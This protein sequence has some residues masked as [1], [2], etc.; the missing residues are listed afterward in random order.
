ML[1]VALDALVNGGWLDAVF[2]TTLVG[3]VVAAKPFDS[4][5]P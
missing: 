1:I 2:A 4:A 3:V 5:G